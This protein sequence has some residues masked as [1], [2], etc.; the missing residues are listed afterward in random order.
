LSG[1]AVGHLS[2]RKARR[3][4][5]RIGLPCALHL[6]SARKSSHPFLLEAHHR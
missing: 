6:V 2:K 5:L 1:S 3:R 4:L